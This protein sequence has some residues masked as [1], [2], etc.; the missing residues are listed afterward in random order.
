VNDTS[1]P[2]PLELVLSVELTCDDGSPLEP[3]GRDDPLIDSDG[4]FQMSFI[5]D[6]ATDELASSIGGVWWREGTERK[7]DDP[8]TAD[9]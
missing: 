8:A 9:G 6:P 1:S 5:H 4:H 3:T 2:S 7:Q